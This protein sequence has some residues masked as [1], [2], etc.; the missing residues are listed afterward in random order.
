MAALLVLL[1]ALGCGRGDKEKREKEAFRIP[2]SLLSPIDDYQLTVDDYHVVRGGV[3]ANAQIELHYPASE[4]AR[5]IAVRNFGYAKAAYEKVAKEIGRPAAGK[6]VIIGATGPEFDEYRVLTRKEWW[7][8]GVVVGDT[9]I[10]QPLD[11]MMRRGIAEVGITQKIAQAAL[12]R[13]SGGRI[14]LWLRESI[15]SRV[16]GENDIITMQMEEFR[17]AG[18]SLV[19]S[20]EA[21]EIA[22]AEASDREETRIAFYCSLR[23]LENLLGT[24]SMDNV[25][26]FLDRLR[27]G[28]TLDQSSQEAFGI[29][30][31]ALIDKIRVD[32]R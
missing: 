21:V 8:Y 32:T 23:M 30:Y 26:S 20:P 27:E 5:F 19:R 3:M 7:Y 24:H 2:D 4:I 14:P 16:A 17:R 11:I 18:H 1:L 29:G 28:K 31:N 25:L 9:I 22:L 6:L 10:F 12:N 13:R 15:A